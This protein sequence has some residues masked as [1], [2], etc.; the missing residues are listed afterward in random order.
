M[1]VSR[2]SEI[3]T[4]I[5]SY[6]SRVRKKSR[7]P[8]FKKHFKKEKSLQKEAPSTKQ[9]ACSISEADEIAIPVS[10]GGSLVGRWSQRITGFFKGTPAKELGEGSSFEAEESEELD[11]EFESELREMEEEELKKE[12]KSGL[13]GFLSRI[14]FLKTSEKVSGDTVPEKEILEG[15]QEESVT[16]GVLERSEVEKDIKKLAIV[17]Q[18]VLHGLPHEK[19]K[20]FKESDDF[21]TYKDVLSKYGLIKEW[22][23]GKD[24]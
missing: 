23:G 12:K 22:S 24:E 16:K 2:K 20:E 19:L 8:F 18:S 1:A 11:K 13:A 5:N 3:N 17:T 6:I 14:N 9:E 10:G 4:E 7:Q 15:E 21:I